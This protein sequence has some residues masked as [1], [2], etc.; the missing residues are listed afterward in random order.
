MNPL[1]VLGEDWGRHPSSTQHLV[2]ELRKEHPVIW[3]NSIGLR[4]P[5]FNFKDMLRIFE[6]LK[7][8]FFSRKEKS[9]SSENNDN[10]SPLVVKPWVIPFHNSRLVRTVNGYL[11]RWKIAKSPSLIT[12]E[13]PI[14]WVSLPTALPLLNTM[15]ESY[16]IYYCGDD[17]S[18]LAGVDHNMVS[19]LEQELAEKVDLIVVASTELK[20][21]FPEHKTLYLPHGVT[22]DF[23][24]AAWSRPKDLPEG[25]VAG[26]YGSLSSWLDQ[27]LIYQTANQLKHWKF[28]FI[29]PKCCDLSR[30]EGVENILFLGE[31]PHSQLPNYARHWQVSM[32]PFLDN[33]QIR[34]CNPLKL[35]E[36]MAT[37]SAIVSTDF[38][39]AKAYKDWL[40]FSDKTNFSKAI[41]LAAAEFDS[42]NMACI[43]KISS[44]N[45][46]ID[47]A[48][49]PLQR[50]AQVSNDSWSCRAQVI[51]SLLKMR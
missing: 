30:L 4:T 45:Q 3:V 7:S 24:N 43:E 23:F 6:K 14:L 48:N 39:A 36:Y 29:G 41:E 32:L 26:F 21:K 12:G 16:S 44:W 8:T 33:S 47:L 31:K 9:G 13:K 40:V 28:V 1:I 42:T 35:R 20:I 46:V 25:P 37:G 11:L 19:R 10:W 2:S 15:G 27:E 34:S 5:R 50:S 51:E 17:F 18:A 22:A 38:P 49:K